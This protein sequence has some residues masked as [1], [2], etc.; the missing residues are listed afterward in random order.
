M[1]AQSISHTFSGE[2]FQ[3]EYFPADNPRATIVIFPTVAGIS[4]LEIGFAGD[5][6]A[7][8][9]SVFVADLYGEEFRGAPRNVGHDNMRRIQSD[10]ATLR[11]RLLAVLETVRGLGEAGQGIAAL[12]FCFGGLCALDLAR[13]GADIAGAASFHGIFDPN[14]LPPRAIKAKAIA[15]HGWD[16][17]MVPPAKVVALA[18]ELSEGGCDWQ[19]LALGNIVHG[20]TNPAVDA[21]NNPAV[22]YSAIASARAW[23]AFDG[24]LDDLFDE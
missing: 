21:F 13:S 2:R 6:N 14:G 4:E 20:F 19:I 18:R 1:S 11:D 22:R 24:F 3:S 9:L 16:D 5:L 17:P 7:K 12:G 23:R 15:F 8:R 10:R